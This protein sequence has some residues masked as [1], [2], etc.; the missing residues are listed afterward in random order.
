MNAI[1]DS[2]AI[3]LAVARDK[4]VFT[5]AGMTGNIRMAKLEEQK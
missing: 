3:G 2:G 1:L 5:Q 4:I